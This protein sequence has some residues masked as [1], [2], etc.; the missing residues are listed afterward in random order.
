MSR[1]ERDSAEQRFRASFERLRAGRPERLPKGTLVSQN[2]VA[3]EAG[4]D[5]S[6]L[7]KSRYPE[8]IREIQA[9]VE[10]ANQQETIDRH[11][12]EKRRRRSESLQE[13][14]KVLR[15]QRDQAQSQLSSAHRQILE[16]LRENK[17][18]E[19]RLAALNPPPTPI[20]R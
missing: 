1:P 5:P 13:K 16:L 9:F 10:I 17:V 7:R 6:A 18:L 15:A 2:N 8:L 3:K 19:A 12:R 11:R 14:V 20:R 4:A